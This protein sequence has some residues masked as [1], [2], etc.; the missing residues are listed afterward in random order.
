M[1]AGSAHPHKAPPLCP[2]SSPGTPQ[3]PASPLLL[4]PLP[5]PLRLWLPLSKVAHTTPWSSRTCTS[6][7]YITTGILSTCSSISSKL[8]GPLLCCLPAGK[9]GS[10]CLVCLRGVGAV[11]TSLLRTAP[12][13]LQ[14]LVPQ[15]R[16]LPPLLRL[17]LRLRLQRLHRS[18]GVRWTHGRR[19]HNTW[20]GRPKA[21]RLPQPITW[22]WKEAA[23]E[24]P[25]I[26]RVLVWVWRRGA[27]CPG[28][29]PSSRTC[30]RVGEAGGVQGQAPITPGRSLVV[31]AVMVVACTRVR[32]L[33]G[34]SACSTCTQTRHGR[35]IDTPWAGWTPCAPSLRWRPLSSRPTRLRLHLVI[36]VTPP[37][38]QQLLPHL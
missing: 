25:I 13:Q 4:L 30:Q 29:A 23:T 19:G 24:A 38:P 2:A 35:N 22:S 28:G 1:R 20:G 37:L 21:P 31:L 7:A 14:S 26:A 15:F 12:T 10:P 32:P 11:A 18:P 33:G 27:H 8:R 5:P 34:P 3:P 36:P 6:R 16:L 17:R 9:G